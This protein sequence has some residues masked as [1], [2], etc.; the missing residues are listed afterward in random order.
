[1]S[2]LLT[3]VDLIPA[4]VPL[5]VGVD[6]KDYTPLLVV[7]S[8]LRQIWGVAAAIVGVRLGTCTPLGLYLTSRNERRIANEVSFI[9]CKRLECRSVVVVAA[10]VIAAVV[11]FC[12]KRRE[13][14]GVGAAAA[15]VIAVVTVRRLGDGSDTSSNGDGG[16]KDLL[17]L[18][19]LSS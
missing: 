5:V 12:F 2:R 19:A 9:N 8:N 14:R 17:R 15:A 3:I 16:C 6:T 10:A 7:F 4:F 18:A 13:C 11:C 1:V